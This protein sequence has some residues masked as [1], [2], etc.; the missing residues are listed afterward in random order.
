MLA[1]FQE[2]L[3]VRAKCNGTSIKDT[4]ADESKD[5]TQTE[6]WSRTDELL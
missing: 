2:T 5:E 6:E 4:S 1:A 3:W